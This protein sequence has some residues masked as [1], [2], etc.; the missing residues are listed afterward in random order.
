VFVALVCGFA[1]LGG[2]VAGAGTKPVPA[3]Y[4]ADVTRLERVEHVNGT[5]VTVQKV[6]DYT[7]EINAYS[8]G[9]GPSTRVVLWDTLLDG[10]LTPGE[11]RV[12]LAHELGHVWHRHI[13]KGL[14][15]FALFAFPGAWLVA[16]VTRRTGGMGRPPRCRS[17]CSRWSS[18]GSWP[19][20]S[21]TLCHGVTKPRPTGPR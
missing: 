9:I 14:A 6:S 10:R 3:R 7:H 13:W 2:W 12:V 16:R 4:R 18:S 15:W 20:R 11:V 8:I 1:L 21:K 19:R 5:P 17:R